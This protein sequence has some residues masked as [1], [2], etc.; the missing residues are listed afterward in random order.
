MHSGCVKRVSHVR[1]T[2]SVVG[3]AVT[4]ET[5]VLTLKIPPG[6]EHG[7]RFVFENE[8]NSRPGV[9]PGPVV[10][11]AQATKHATFH[12]RGDDLVFVARRSLIDGLCGTTVSLTGI[13]GKQLS[14]P[15][16]EIVDAGSCKV[17][18]GEGMARRAENGG[19]RGDLLVV[20]DLVFPKTLSPLQREMMR[21]AFFFPGKNPSKEAQK[22]A[23][24]FLLAA[25]DGVKGWSTGGK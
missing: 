24:A 19:G 21:A 12:R 10:Y 15:V 22:A 7:R 2:Q 17:V 25:N 3:G 20:F 8:G 13:D 11:V 5:R 23:T 4:E 16:E 1:K 18:S 9:N 6:C 14:I